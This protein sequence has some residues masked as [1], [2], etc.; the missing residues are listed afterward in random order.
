MGLGRVFRRLDELT[1]NVAYVRDA[2]V[3]DTPQTYITVPQL[4]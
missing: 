1:V 4:V 2:Y 3:T